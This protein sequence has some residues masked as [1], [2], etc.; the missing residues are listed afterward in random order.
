M[1]TSAS[2]SGKR[3]PLLIPEP[4]WHEWTMKGE[5]ADQLA[6]LQAEHGEAVERK[7]DG[8]QIIE[9]VLDG[10]PAAD[11]DTWKTRHAGRCVGTSCFATRT[12]SS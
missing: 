1:P 10:K 8:C 9:E 5:D 11:F 4:I 7:F 2:E 12:P 6:E 3:R